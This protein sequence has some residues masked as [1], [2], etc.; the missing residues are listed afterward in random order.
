M[1][2]CRAAAATPVGNPKSDGKA[3]GAIGQLQFLSLWSS[4]KPAC[5]AL[6]ILDIREF[7]E[8]GRQPAWGAGP[9]CS[10]A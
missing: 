1:Y 6:L 3:A 5:A 7:F 8:K 9:D 10:A 2:Q 4:G